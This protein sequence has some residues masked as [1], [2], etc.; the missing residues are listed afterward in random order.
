LRKLPTK[1]SLEVKIALVGV[2][3]VGKSAL[4]VQH[5]QGIFVD[6]Y[7]PTIEDSYRK[8]TTLNF[9]ELAD[10]DDDDSKARKPKKGK[11]KEA[12]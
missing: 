10:D 2:G 4:I 9:L 6:C 3:G 5:V 12:N 7:D 8:Q 11:K 1:G